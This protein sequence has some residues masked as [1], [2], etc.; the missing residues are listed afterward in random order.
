M[1]KSGG[2][3]G[4]GCRF[5]WEFAVGD[6]D[7]SGWRNG[8]D[9]GGGEEVVEADFKGELAG[10]DGGIYVSKRRT[11]AVFGNQCRRG[12]FILFGGDGFEE[13]Q[14]DKVGIG[15]VGARG[16]VEGSVLGGNG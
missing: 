5:G 14:A 13:R 3:C 15:S 10:G 12:G 16:F 6:S 2:L 9:A 11:N 4:S 1:G 7:D 8:V